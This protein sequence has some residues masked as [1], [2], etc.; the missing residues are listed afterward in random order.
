MKQSTT[1]LLT[2]ITVISLVGAIYYFV[3][4]FNHL[5]TDGTGSQP[6]LGSICTI[7]FLIAFITAVQLTPKKVPISSGSNTFSAHTDKY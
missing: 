4:G 6:T 5:F 2:S 1:A 3:P 7:V